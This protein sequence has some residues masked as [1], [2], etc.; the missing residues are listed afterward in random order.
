MNHEDGRWEFKYDGDRKAKLGMA[1]WFLL[2]GGL[3]LAAGIGLGLWALLGEK[4]PASADDPDKQVVAQ[5][6]DLPDLP[7]LSDLNFGLLFQKTCKIFLKLLA[8]I[9]LPSLIS[10]AKDI[11]FS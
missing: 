2:V 11:F 6:P 3:L 9:S 1:V 7:D 10:S 4:D 8:M 5:Q